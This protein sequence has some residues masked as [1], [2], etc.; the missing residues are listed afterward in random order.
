MASDALGNAKSG[1]RSLHSEVSSD[2]RGDERDADPDEHAKVDVRLD[3]DGD[4][5]SGEDEDSDGI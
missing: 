1:S 4:T 5:D 3:E 2:P